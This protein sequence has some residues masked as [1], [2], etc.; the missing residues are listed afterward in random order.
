MPGTFDP[1]PPPLWEGIFAQAPLDVYRQHPRFRTEFSPVFYRGRLDGTSRVLIIGQDPSTDEILAQRTLVGAA[2][3]R[4]QGLLT[5]LGL[6][7]SYT[8][9]NTFLYGIR[10][11]F[12]TTM[13]SLSAS[14][15]ILVHRNTI[16]DQFA[17]DNPLEAVIALGQGAQHALD[18]WPGAQSL[19]VFKLVHPTS[20][21]GAPASWNQNLP[22]MLAAIAPDPGMTPDPTPYGPTFTPQD[23]SAIPRADMPFG[24]PDWHGTGGTR[25]SRGGTKTKITWTA[26]ES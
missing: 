9:F 10:Q 21:Q 3:Q 16:F 12:D 5:K 20:P 13:R 4:V 23:D 17:A 15:P 2:G 25:S 14:G 6:A 26:P 19:T 8:M 18:H 1:G 22:Q 7:T 24:I 11:Q